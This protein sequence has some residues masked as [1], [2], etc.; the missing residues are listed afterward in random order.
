M[1]EYHVRAMF[2]YTISAN[3]EKQAKERADIVKLAFTDGVP[4]TIFTKP[5][6]HSNLEQESYEFEESWILA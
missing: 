1:K 4:E 2:T 6:F 3:N 5:W